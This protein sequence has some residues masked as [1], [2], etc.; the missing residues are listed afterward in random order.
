MD[1]NE[2]CSSSPRVGSGVG[3]GRPL[4]AFCACTANYATA[5][6]ASPQAGAFGAVV[7]REGSADAL[8]A[9]RNTS[10][11]LGS[12]PQTQGRFGGHVQP[13]VTASLKRFFTMRSSPEWYAS[14]TRACS[15]SEQRGEG[16]VD[17]TG[18]GSSS[19]SLTAMRSAWNVRVAGWPPVRRAAAGMA[20]RTS[21]ASSP[22]V[23]IGR[24]ADDGAGDA[25]RLSASFPPSRRMR[26]QRSTEGSWLMRSAAARARSCGPCAC[27]AA[28]RDGTRNLAH[29]GQAAVSSHLDRTER[30]YIDRVR[31]RNI[32]E[33]VE[34]VR[35]SRA[36]P[37][38]KEQGAP[39]PHQSHPNH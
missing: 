13:P 15:H 9:P 1:G 6:H 21:S 36:A 29:R 37:P 18:E 23:V 17:R 28:R 2:P 26:R 4:E 5:S 8:R 39:G 11:T 19:S 34:C 35:C 31:P 25:L 20:L 30:R 16:V 24:D 10:F 14:T 22:V 33:R 7:T 27:R 32:G 12:A 38:D 3:I